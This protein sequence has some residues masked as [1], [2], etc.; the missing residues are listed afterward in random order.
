MKNKAVRTNGTMKSTPTA[1]SDSTSRL[2]G[3]IRSPVGRALARARSADQA[4]V[5]LPD[6]F[7]FTRAPLGSVP[8]RHLVDHHL[9]HRLRQHRAAMHEASERVHALEHLIRGAGRVLERC[10]EVGLHRLRL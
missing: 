3:M 4:D 5:L 9:L 8:G 1:R 6:R 7:E 10:L 2:L